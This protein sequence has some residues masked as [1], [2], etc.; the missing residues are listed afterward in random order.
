MGV[1]DNQPFCVSSPLAPTSWLLW[2]F[3]YLVHHRHWVFR[4]AFFLLLILL[5]DL[6]ALLYLFLVR[7]HIARWEAHSSNFI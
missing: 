1:F 6:V 7:V 5:H 4:L 2:V 3:E